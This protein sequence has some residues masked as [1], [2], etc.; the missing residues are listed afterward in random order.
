MG[1]EFLAFDNQ[2]VTALTSHNQDDDFV[3]LNIIQ[4][5]Q[6]PRPQLVMGERIWP[7]ALDGL[8]GR[9][10]LV[11]QARLD[12]RFED[13]LLSRRQRSQLPFSILSDRDLERHWRE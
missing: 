12:R 13:S 7:Q 4:H 1:I 8:C 10:G 6:V 3:S 5:S 11:L 2:I 9:G